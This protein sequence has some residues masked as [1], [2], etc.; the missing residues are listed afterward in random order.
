MYRDVLPDKGSLGGF[1][2]RC[3]TQIA[4]SFL[5]LACDMPFISP[6]LLRFMISQ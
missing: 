3:S 4:S 6:D 5:V 2:P 1:T